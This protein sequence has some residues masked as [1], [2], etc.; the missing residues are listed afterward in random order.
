MIM[1][2]LLFP[3]FSAQIRFSDVTFN[4]ILCD[5]VLT[6]SMDENH[7]AN[8]TLKN[9]QVAYK[10]NI[11][12]SFSLAEEIVG[13]IDYQKYFRIDWND[14]MLTPDII[15]SEDPLEIKREYRKGQKLELD[16]ED[17]RSYRVVY[18]DGVTADFTHTGE[19]AY[20]FSF[21]TG[22]HGN[23]WKDSDGTHSIRFKGIRLDAD[24]DGYS[25]E[26]KF[27]FSRSKYTDHLILIMQDDATVYL[28]I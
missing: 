12:G 13:D 18:N 6:I 22:F 1:K 4:L 20:D 14:D 16:I 7:Y 3:N 19:H 2:M 24:E 11:L 15:F 23:L 10:A 21:S 27:I 28:N 9:Q 5:D 26:S 8:I 25:S 17:V